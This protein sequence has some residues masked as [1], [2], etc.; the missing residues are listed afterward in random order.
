[1]LG[2]NPAP[3]R[4]DKLEGTDKVRK[5]V[6]EGKSVEKITAGWQGQLEEFKALREKYLL[7]P[8]RGIPQ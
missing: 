5:M 6:D 1:L 4:I 2:G 7:Y 3:Y 8:L